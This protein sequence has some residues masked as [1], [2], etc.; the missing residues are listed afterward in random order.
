MKALE[1][2][3]RS[4]EQSYQLEVAR[5]L[6][7]DDQ[8]REAFKGG[9][10]IQ[11][12]PIPKHEEETVR[13]QFLEEE[14]EKVN[15]QSSVEALYPFSQ[16]R[17]QEQEWQKAIAVIMNENRELKTMLRE[18]ETRLKEAEGRFA[19]P[20]EEGP[21]G[22]KPEEA[23]TPQRRE[24][25]GPRGRKNQEAE[26]PRRRSRSRSEGHTRRGDAMTERSLEFMSLMMES[27]KEMQRKMSESGGE[28]GMIRGV[29]TVRSGVPELPSLPAWSPSQG[30]LQLGDWMLTISP[31]IADLSVTSE[32]WWEKTMKLAE[33]WYKD[34][35]AMS[36]INRLAHDHQTP[37]E[38]SEAKWQRLERRVATMMLQSLPEAVREELIASRRM[39]VYGIVTYLHLAYC[40]GGVQEKQQLLK[41]LEEPSEIQA[42][43]DLPTAI[44][45][46]MR[47]Q[48]RSK[49]I[50]AVMPDPT[51]LLKGL[52]RMSKRVLEA[53]KD[54]Q[55]RISLARNMLG[56][57]T[58]PT[59]S[60]VTS[61]ATHL[62]AECEQA[63]FLEKKT[64]GPRP[65]GPKI[66]AADGAE[67]EEKKGK[68][69]GKS[70]EEE[71]GDDDARRKKCRFYLSDGGCRK[72]KACGWSHDQK[73]ERRR[74]WNCGSIEHMQ[75]ACT[76]PRTAE[77]GSPSKQKQMKEDEKPGT[78][79]GAKN[80]EDS[81]GSDSSPVVRGLL[82]EANKMLRNLQGASSSTSTTTQGHQEKEG[83][84]T[85]DER[86]ELL[87][88]LQHQLNSLR[89]FKISKVSRGGVHGLLDSGATHPLRSIKSEERGADYPMIEV[90]LADGRTTRLKMSPGGA[91]LT[92][93]EAAEPIVPMGLL[94]QKLGCTVRWKKEGLEVIHPGRGRL[95]VWEIHGCPQVS[96]RLALELIHELEEKT[97]GVSQSPKPCEDEMRWMMKLVEKHE[98]LSTLPTWIKE[99]LVVEPGPWN[100]L[101]C[102]RRWRKRLQR[103]GMIAHLY[104][105]EDE[106]FTLTQ[107]WRQ[108]GGREQKLLEIDI[109]RGSDHDMLKD[110][111][112]YAALLTAAL[113]GKL[114]AV[115]G[116]PNCRT[117]SVLRHYP[118]PGQAS[119]PRPVRKWGGQEYGIHDA[120]PF[121]W[122]QLQE[123]D[124]LMWRMIFLF[125]IST[126]MKKAMG[127]KEKVAFIVEQPSTPREYK[128][129]VVS[130][131]DTKEW[132]KLREEFQLT[133]THVKQGTMG[134]LSQKPTTFGGNV[135]LPAEEYQRRKREARGEVRSSKDLSRWAP[136]VMSMIASSLM[137]EVMKEVPK[138]KAMSWQEHVAMNHVPYR[139]DCLICQQ[140]QQ[141][142]H[143][144]RK[145]A[146]PQGGILSL[147]VAG[148]LIPAKDQG[149]F[150]A[151]YFLVGAL[152][153]AVP[154][155]IEALKEEEVVK[156]EGDEENP[157]IDQKEEEEEEN[158]EGGEAPENV[159]GQNEE[160]EVI[161]DAEPKEEEP[162]PEDQ[163][164]EKKLDF[165]IRVFRTA[166]PMVTK[167]SKEVARTAM[168]MILKFK[169][170]GYEVGRVHSDQG[171]EFSGQFKTWAR[172]RGIFT[173]RTP[174][175]DPRGNGRAEVAVKTIKTQ[176]RRLLRQA[177]VGSE[178]WPWAVRYVSEMNR[179]YRIHEFPKFPGFLQEVLV[180]KRKWQSKDFEVTV[181][182]CKYLAPASEEHGHWIQKE[183]EAPRLTRC[184]MK[185]GE[186]PMNLDKWLA[187][188]K[189][190]LD[191]FTQRRRLREKTA[192]RRMDGREEENQE[193][194][195]RRM[196]VAKVIEEEMKRII[197]D[198]EETAA[199][200]MKLIA[201]L[202]KM[203]EPKEGE[204]EEILQ[205][206]IISPKEVSREWEK[207]LPAVESEVRS[208]L[209]EK[210]ALKPISQADFEEILAKAEAQGGR[211]ELVPSKVVF[212]RKPAPGGG[213]LKVRWVVCGNYETKTPE[214]ETYSS[215]GDATALRILVWATS[216]YQWTA[217]ILD[218]HTAFL[219]AELNQ[220]E[221]K[222][223]IVIKPPSIFVEKGYLPRLRYY[224][225][226]K[227][228]YGLRRSPRL[229]GL[230]RDKRMMD[231]VIELK[232]GKTRLKLRMRPLE[233]EQNM[234][235]IV[236]EG[237]ETY[238]YGLVMTYV[239]DMIIAAEDDVRVAVQEKI[240]EAWTTS[241]PEK[242]EEEPRRFLGMEISKR[243][244]EEE[245][246]EV[247][248]MTQTSYIL[249]M[250]SKEEEEVKERRIP[251]S[252]DQSQP[253]DDEAPLTPEEVKFNQKLTGELLWLLTRT[254]PDIMFGVS[255]IGSRITKSRRLKE[256]GAQMKGYLKSTSNH[257]LKMNGGPDEWVTLNVFTDASFAP[258]SEESH[259]CFVVLLDESPI[260]WRS[261][262]QALVTLSTAESELVEIIE[263]MIG[264]EAVVTII[265]EI[266]PKVLKTL[267]SDSQSAVSIL[268]S[269]SGSW[270]TR[271]LRLRSTFARQAIQSGDW[272]LKNMMG[273]KMIADIGT[274]PLP[275]A[276][277]EM[278]KK[279]MGMGQRK[280][281][282][283]EE[284][285]EGREE[286]KKE[287]EEKEIVRVPFDEERAKF[288]VQLITLATSLTHV[289]A[290]EIE[291]SEGTWLRTVVL[292]ALVILVSSFLWWKRGVRSA[293]SRREEDPRRPPTEEEDETSSEE[294]SV[295][296]VSESRDVDLERR[297]EQ[298]I[299]QDGDESQEELMRRIEHAMEDIAEEERRWEWIFTQREITPEEEQD[300]LSLQPAF[301]V[302]TTKFG[303]VYHNSHCRVLTSPQTGVA[304]ESTWCTI[305]RK[306]ARESRGAPPPGI[307][308]W[309]LGWGV[310]Y[311]TNP[312]C[313]RNQRTRT[314]RFPFCQICQEDT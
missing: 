58:M 67:G 43:G 186:E 177:E 286:V 119:C 112:P 281:R 200:E 227:A 274:K 55:F 263:G 96:K 120:T 4:E 208:L 266:F 193:E 251:I 202:K 289:K 92:E 122:Q 252:R 305:C 93:D 138:M 189:E 276:R 277:L 247:W 291:E 160:E 262:K 258:D 181:E 124:V 157:R 130:W 61:F 159:E 111:G 211:V 250:I 222:V 20:E 50:G 166:I 209:E 116:G 23:E 239:D 101:P 188:E 115:L 54:L 89:V 42:L 290:E 86:Q 140:T 64:A 46:W 296:A 223:I 279:E 48:R 15:N 268:G 195:K 123:D 242:I 22:R 32:V 158:V 147:D 24:E 156:E 273:E 107:A 105:G 60:A 18:M 135:D 288:A 298:V 144:H 244:E 207:W 253:P 118:I 229:W 234:W 121:E 62:L 293:E 19:T 272:R 11:T 145:V 205:T 63:S 17:N 30:P 256:I 66:K 57:D 275:A 84:R 76:R 240:Q 75:P 299:R 131:W 248:M 139:R 168:D 310:E 206:K 308:V 85:N 150:R 6:F 179:C 129:E 69:K 192:V 136:G 33:K 91:M 198:E 214:E 231:M 155:T 261:G 284:H 172:N 74:C 27:M 246:R 13:P 109:K 269:E 126:Y 210:E 176:V 220:E 68:G 165:D 178:W 134:G 282:N 132:A 183:N 257:G 297:L 233:S 117:R 212:T 47:W 171:H 99:R 221:A 235:R 154:K 245:E 304:R 41:N 148:P 283:T 56:V 167:T 264:G 72:G 254:R 108:L 14:E 152:T 267:W 110:R 161:R 65:D 278:L 113:Q 215:G 224:M 146:H 70:Y 280:E 81:A 260:F 133:E 197:D 174:G 59:E 191:A 29:E 219:N 26:T 170:D 102:N 309:V 9:G 203:V 38:L 287:A 173:T 36:P 7:T 311:H 40:P 16:G 307:E 114:D 187:V 12:T 213:K 94:T 294:G 236:E 302:F 49:E 225:P 255:K 104:A 196:R 37:P 149:G 128:P 125:M 53:N 82:E 163:E 100:L 137:I 143:P 270:R 51:I 103:D 95:D 142:C 180:R 88:R 52:N 21:R 71:R 313:P 306:I 182:V 90:S 230:C 162:K 217:A 312:R 190:A 141:Q 314:E 249:D 79:H 238:L 285:K 300:S 194:Q 80:E 2:K 97:I 218:V 237:E 34:H 226:L 241:P 31:I 169:A 292:T 106:G 301:R 98:V 232:R 3:D 185:K 184:F 295:I 175:D 259:G 25:E 73:D 204:E 39:S 199:E 5:P 151:R 164:E 243:W 216:K 77:G 8:V 10:M 303:K 265:N 78:S 271:H 87:N 45:R 83:E 44:R 127:K 228:V 201:Q 35:M 28:S 153:W 1:D